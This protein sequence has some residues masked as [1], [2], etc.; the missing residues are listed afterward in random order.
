M[1]LYQF[2]LPDRSND[3][4]VD[5][6]SARLEWSRRAIG[7][8]GGLTSLAPVIGRW[9]DFELDAAGHATNVGKQYNEMMWPVQVACGD[10]REAMLADAFELFPDQVSIFVATI[11]EAS[12]EARPAI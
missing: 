10:Y 9:V 7:Y 3:G 11:G 2:N 1:K 5:Y 6:H 12:I 4:T 8:C